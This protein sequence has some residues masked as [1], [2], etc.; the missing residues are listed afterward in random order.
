MNMDVIS[1]SK[2]NKT[3]NKIKQLDESVVAPLAE[4]RFPTVD[5]RLDW[6]EGQ[7][8]KIKVENSKQL[9]LSLGIFNN[10][11]IIDGKVRLK[12]ISGNGKSRFQSYNGL[13]GNFFDRN[14]SNIAREIEVV[15]G[16]YCIGTV[17]GEI[18]RYSLDGTYLGSVYTGSSQNVDGITQD[19]NYIYVCHYQST[20]KWYRFN[21]DWSNKQE[22][23]ITVL[24]NQLGTIDTNGIMIRDGFLYLISRST[25]RIH[26]FSYTPNGLQALVFSSS[27]L[28][29]N[30]W[31]IQDIYGEIHC[32]D[33]NGL[34]Y[35]YDEHTDTWT[36]LANYG[37]NIIA[38]TMRPGVNGEVVALSYNQKT[39]KIIDVN[40]NES[41]YHSRGT[42]ESPIIDLGEGWKKTKLV[43]IVKQIHIGI[44]N[45]SFEIATSTDGVSFTSYVS[46][47]PN[48]LP[49]A[50]Y[51]KLRATLSAQAQPGQ[52]KTLDFNQSSPENTMTL[53]EYTEANGKLQLKNTYTYSMTDD[54]TLGSGK[55]FSFIINKAN[56]KSIN[57][58]E[59]Q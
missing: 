51:I 46:L 37:N 25:N 41:I 20:N 49:Q 23:D 43:D 14:D 44:T 6:L 32:T 12:L 42:W 7:A 29:K 59:V 16:E 45:V 18:E 21:K 48:A 19:E 35:R 10:T 40:V 33:A 26:K 55:Q 3:L 58:L 57:S 30:W 56:F 22:F 52:T 15:N 11:E 50:R 8:A 4:D 13:S 27:V 34:I 53:N 5:A 54:G 9:D 28:Q 1:L 17:N 24:R 39:L 47:D 31:S 38:L 2:A 36:Q